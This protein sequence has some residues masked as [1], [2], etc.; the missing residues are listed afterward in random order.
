MKTSKISFRSKYVI[1][2]LAGLLLTTLSAYASTTISTNFT[3][4]VQ[5][6]QKLVLT[7]DGSATGTTGVVIDGLS[8]K[9]QANWFCDSDGNNCKTVLCLTNKKF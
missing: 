3:N 7:N 1:V 2:F 6:I 9:V 4:V 8:G 5:Y